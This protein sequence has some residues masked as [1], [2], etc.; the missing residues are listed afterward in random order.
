[1]IDSHLAD[2]HHGDQGQKPSFLSIGPGAALLSLVGV[3]AC[4]TLLATQKEM[5][6][7]YLLGLVFWT[8]IT[9]GCF[10][11]TVL[12][13]VVK[14]SWALPLLRIFE[15]GGSWVSLA[16]MAFLFLPIA[17]KPDWFFSWARPEAVDI[18]AV[19]WKI[20]YLNPTFFNVRLVFYFLVWARF[21]WGFRQSTLKQDETLDIKLENN[22]SNWA[23]P[24]LLIFFITTTFAFTDWAM[25][26]DPKWYSTMWGLMFAITCGSGA[27]A[28]AV[29]MFATN[30]HKEPYRSII[31]KNLT[32]DMGNMMFVMTMLWGYVNISQLIIIW[33]G[34]IPE[35]AVYYAQRSHMGWN[36]V[37][38]A[39]IFGVFFIP[40]FSLITPRVKRTP[41]R[42]ARIAGWIF[43]VTLI[44]VYFK[45]LPFVRPSAMP[46][47][48]DVI[49]LASVGAVWAMAFGSQI[50]IGRLVPRYDNRLEEAVK[51]AH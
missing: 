23:A 42:L 13:H 17:I 24:G 31:T 51:N 9:V 2:A 47:V 32:K 6:N 48:F 26:L 35:T 19:Q 43:V 33:N 18:H 39:L 5:A 21:A 36:F 37:G 3:I 46:N 45:L 25:S 20:K 10:G 14:G 28:L 34:N 40:F 50:K 49:A 38:L 4:W 27:L 44:D 11:M 8:C 22:R 16:L 41:E 15:A 1:M 29:Y 7:A 30:A 12:H